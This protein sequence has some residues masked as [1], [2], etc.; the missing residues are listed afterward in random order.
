MEQSLW[1]ML[2]KHIVSIRDM[3]QSGE[4]YS[5]DIWDEKLGDAINYLAILKAITVDKDEKEERDARDAS[6]ESLMDLREKLTGSRYPSRASAEI[7]VTKDG[8]TFVNNQNAY[9]LGVEVGMTNQQRDL[10][11]VKRVADKLK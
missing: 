4:S 1:G 7:T 6:N 11:S 10:E 3:V 9:S 2:T 8:S 5:H